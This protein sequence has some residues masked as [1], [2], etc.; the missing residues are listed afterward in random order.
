[1]IEERALLALRGSLGSPI[2]NIRREVGAL[3][4]ALDFEALNAVVDDLSANGMRIDEIAVAAADGVTLI[5]PDRSAN[6]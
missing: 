3:P 5:G 6:R 1:M 2:A 4:A